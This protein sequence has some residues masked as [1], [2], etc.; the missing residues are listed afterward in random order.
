MHAVTR[1]DLPR[2]R[3]VT[4]VVHAHAGGTLHERLD[5]HRGRRG[6]MPRKMRIERRCGRTNVVHR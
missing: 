5:D 1:G 4:R 2:E 3:E 6:V